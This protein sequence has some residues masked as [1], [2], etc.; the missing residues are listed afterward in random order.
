MF[1]L[2]GRSR[3][4]LLDALRKKRARK[5]AGPKA[6]RDLAEVASAEP[7]EKPMTVPL[8]LTPEKFWGSGKG[9]EELQV[10]I[11]PPAVNA[12]VLRRLGIAPFWNER[13]DFFELMGE[14]YARVS[15]FAVDRAYRSQSS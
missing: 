3:E 11:A 1:H 5:G 15:R 8:A 10:S 6:A 14:L 4:E 12:P 2:R 13:K 9:F 7:K